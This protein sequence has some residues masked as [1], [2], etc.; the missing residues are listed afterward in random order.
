[1]FFPLACHINYC[2]ICT[3]LY[4]IIKRPPKPVGLDAL[5]P[6]RDVPADDVAPKRP[7]V[8]PVFVLKPDV[9]PVDP[10]LFAA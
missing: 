6:K 3:D 10:F 9:A 8:V 7:P 5:F 4:Q 2:C 1:M